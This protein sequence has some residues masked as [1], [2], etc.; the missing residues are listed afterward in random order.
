[1]SHALVVAA[2]STKTAMEKTSSKQVVLNGFIEHTLLRQ[3]ATAADIKQL[4]EE[5]MEYQ[6]YGVCV[7]PYFVEQAK[8]LLA[9]SHQKV[10][11]VV[12]FPFGYSITS[13]KVEATKK[14]FEKGA[15]EIDMVMNLSA[16]RSGDINYVRNDIESVATIARLQDK[17]VK[18]IIESGVL[19]DD[20]I[21]TACEICV[22]AGVDFVKTSTGYAAN[23]AS[24]EHVKLIKECL[25]AKIKIK[26]SGG[27]K[28][29]AFALA[30]VEAGATRIGTSAGVNLVA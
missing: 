7:S 8:K 9:N 22:Q 12:G 20:E 13:V 14:A 28:D 25:P 19:T 27:I 2:R 29:K 23:G 3:D 5:A 6:F 17:V 26:A 24:V 30:L 16:L 4:C 11:T 15:D 21:K 10:I 18:V 1:M